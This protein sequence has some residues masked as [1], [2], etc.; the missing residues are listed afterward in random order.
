MAICTD[1]AEFVGAAIGLNLIFGVPLAPAGAITGVIAFL[2][3]RLQARGNRRFE[4]AVLTSLGL[5]AAG[6]AYETLRIGPSSPSIAAAASSRIF[7][8]PGAS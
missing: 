6:F 1:I 7:P 4:I 8:A 3:L 2:V 5:I